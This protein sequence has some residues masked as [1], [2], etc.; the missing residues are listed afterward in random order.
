MG[1]ASPFVPLFRE[2]K[3][4]RYLWE[5]PV[6]MTNARLVATLGAEPHTPLEEAVRA[7]LIGLVCLDAQN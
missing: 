5:T 1:L 3:E 6:R 2:L 7:T 4:M